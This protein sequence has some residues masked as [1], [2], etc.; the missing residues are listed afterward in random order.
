M[1]KP[2]P[3]YALFGTPHIGRRPKIVRVVVTDIFPLF[4]RV[5]V[6]ELPA[7]NFDPLRNELVRHLLPIDRVANLKTLAR[8]A[9][10]FAAP[11]TRP[12]LSVAGMTAEGAAK[13][14]TRKTQ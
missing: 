13:P 2:N 6:F 11:E 1:T 3:A 12:P 10:T 7:A 8:K 14:S 4:R 5:A 9:I